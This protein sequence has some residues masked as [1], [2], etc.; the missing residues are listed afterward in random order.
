VTIHANTAEVARD[1]LAKVG[2][3]GHPVANDA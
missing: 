1:V 2:W 3:A